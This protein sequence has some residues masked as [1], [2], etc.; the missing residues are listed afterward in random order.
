[1]WSDL[2]WIAKRYNIRNREA[3][4]KMATMVVKSITST[5][6]TK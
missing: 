5:I 3:Q 1:V 4:F 6:T 2:D